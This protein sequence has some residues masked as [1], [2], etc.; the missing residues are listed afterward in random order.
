MRFQRALI[1]VLVGVASGLAWNQWSGR[2]IELH[3]NALVRP[4]E[5]AE[6]P[7][8]EAKERMAK[9]ALVL[10]ARSAFFYK[11]GHIPGALLLPEDGFEAAF[12]Q[13]E[14]HL[15]D[16]LDII[17]YCAGM[18]CEASHIVARRLREKGFPAVVLHEGW[19]AWTDAGYPT[20]EGEQP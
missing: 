4:G 12:P 9:G 13:V 18:G 11:V 20:K 2:G 16:S 8:A 10:D 19:P 5:P 3:A 7:A 1:L 14:P 17:V 6:I 15:K